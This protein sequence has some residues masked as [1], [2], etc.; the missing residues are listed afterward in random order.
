[1]IPIVKGGSIATTGVHFV[2][3]I[4]VGA[5]SGYIVDLVLKVLMM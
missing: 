5:V 4:W 2:L 1:M 3:L